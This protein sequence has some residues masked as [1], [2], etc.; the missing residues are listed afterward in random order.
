MHSRDGQSMLRSFQRND[1]FAEVAELIGDPEKAQMLAQRAHEV[2]VEIRNAQFRAEHPKPSRSQTH[3][4]IKQ[5]AVAARRFR[6]ARQR[7]VGMAFLDVPSNLVRPLVA[8]P[9]ETL[10]DIIKYAEQPLHDLGGGTPTPGQATC[11]RIVL[12]AW[13]GKKPGHNNPALARACEEYWLA[14]GGTSG[15]GNWS[16][17]IRRGKVE[18]AKINA[19]QAKINARWPNFNSSK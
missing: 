7:I 18:Q 17:A 4:A 14:C 6:A 3:K 2:E 12:E 5:I 15:A 9:L 16:R 13:P 10:D 19:R 8:V 11:A 1:P